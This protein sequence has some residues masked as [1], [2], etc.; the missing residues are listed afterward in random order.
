L[1][2]ICVAPGL[3]LCAA[4][5]YRDGDWAGRILKCWERAYEE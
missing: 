3:G 4:G 2:I 1:R 5:V